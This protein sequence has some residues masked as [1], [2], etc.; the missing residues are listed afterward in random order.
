MTAQITTPEAHRT[1]WESAH[2]IPDIEVPVGWYVNDPMMGYDGRQMSLRSEDWRY[3]ID[4]NGVPELAT[5]EGPYWAELRVQRGGPASFETEPIHRVTAI[6]PGAV[7]EA[8]YLLV[9]QAISHE[10]GGGE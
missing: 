4:I 2:P 6:E 5:I 9:G 1:E 3:H 8:V 10:M 7:Q